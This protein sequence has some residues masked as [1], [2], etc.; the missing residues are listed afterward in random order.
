MNWSQ[1][2]D[3]VS[4]M[5][6]AGAVAASWSLTQEVAGLSPFTIMTNILKTFRENLNA[7][8]VIHKMG[9]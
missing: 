1:F 7:V 4:H 5:F 6:L 3:P 8:N 9:D 2:K